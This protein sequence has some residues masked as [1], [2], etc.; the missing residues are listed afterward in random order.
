MYGEQKS[1]NYKQNTKKNNR[2]GLGENS[3]L[4]RMCDVFFYV[5]FW[6]IVIGGQVGQKIEWV[7]M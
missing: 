7:H 4:E 6:M 5:L 3:K 2:S 1:E